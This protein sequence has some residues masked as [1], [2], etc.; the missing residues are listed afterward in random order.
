MKEK[1]E[2]G[3]QAI[4]LDFQI[5]SS[6]DCKIFGLAERCKGKISLD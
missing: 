6:K 5:G 2:S 1:I 4:S 3:P